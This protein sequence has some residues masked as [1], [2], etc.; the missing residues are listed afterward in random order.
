[1]TPTDLI[2]ND[3]TALAAKVHSG[4]VTATE[5]IKAT[6]HN[7]E[8]IEPSVNAFRIMTTELAL[9]D[10]ARI[11]ELSDDERRALPLAGVPVAIKDDTDVAGHST[12]WGTAIDRGVCSADAEIV[13]RLRQAGAIIIGKTNVPEL[14]LWP[15]TES[16]TWGT[17]HNP[18]NLD[19]TPGGSSGGS[20]AAVSSGMA[21]MALGSDGGGSVRYPAALTGL[22]GLKPQRDRL[23]LGP[24]HAS[25]WHGLIALGPLTRSVRDAALFLDVTANAEKPREFRDAIDGASRSLTVAVAV[26]PPPG[27]QVSLPN[28]GRTTIDDA[29]QLLAALG[30]DIVEAKIDY[31]LASLWNSTVRLLRG[32]HD[33]VASLPNRNQ[34]ERRTRTVARL[35]KAIPNRTLAKALGREPDISAAMNEVFTTADVVMTPL[36]QS[37]APTLK[38]C[39]KRGAMRS[40]RAANTSAWL[41]P[42]NL[43]GQPAI[44]VPTGTDDRGLPT[45]IHLVGRTGDEATLL[46]LAADIERQRP[47]PKLTE[48]PSNN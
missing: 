29:T 6:L 25:G 1:M 27:S 34:L 22:I 40:L 46:A 7:I 45:A 4:E 24:E 35:G 48:Q 10:A 16:K 28:A 5:L 42:W 3:A 20:A 15:W 41:V 26:N 21:A 12:M 32:A 30:H 44:A 38:K 18:W 8:T 47:F 14:T 9:E 23:P 43:S 37:P 11:D 36:C 13:H 19:H 2:A 17:T 39:P 33:D 31:G